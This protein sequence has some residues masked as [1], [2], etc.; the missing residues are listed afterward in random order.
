MHVMAPNSAHAGASMAF[1]LLVGLVIL[2]RA[3]NVAAIVG[4]GFVVAA[5]I[6][7]ARSGARSTPVTTHGESGLL[8]P[9]A[10]QIAHSRS[11]NHRDVIL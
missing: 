3:P 2:G 5:G 6:G 7:A 8:L 9:P 11:A 10:V 4:I 1:A